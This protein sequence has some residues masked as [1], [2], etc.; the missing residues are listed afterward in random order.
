MSEQ[1]SPVVGVVGLGA[2]G[3]PMAVNLVRAGFTTVVR[4]RS[5][6]ACDQAAAAGA[7]VAQ[8]LRQLG[9]RC[10]GDTHRAP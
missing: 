3:L 1:A 7:E 10:S 2:M 5:S 4:N 9:E 6:S 8:S